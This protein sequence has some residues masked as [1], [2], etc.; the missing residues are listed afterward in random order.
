MYLVRTPDGLVYTRD[1]DLGL[2]RFAADGLGV[3]A[4]IEDRELSEVIYRVTEESLEDDYDL[5]NE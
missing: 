5:F 4:T 3:G 1:A 2:C